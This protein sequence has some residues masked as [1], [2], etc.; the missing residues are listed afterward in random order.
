M[1]ETLRAY[2][3]DGPLAALLGGAPRRLSVPGLLVLAP[4]TLAAGLVLDGART[5]VWTVAGVL[6]FVVLGIA[7]RATPAGAAFAWLLPATLRLGE[8]GTIVV[9]AWRSGGAA[10]AVTYGALAAIAFHHYDIVYRLR[11]QRLPP[12]RWLGWLGGGWE[13]RLLVLTA[14]AWAGV[15]LPV[16][17]AMASWLGL[18]YVTESAAS[19]IAV[20][21]DE[22]RTVAAG[23]DDEGGED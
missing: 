22:Q 17:I 6:A 18:L 12:P 13:V 16:L 11:H 20:A 21:R 5:G 4:V 15:L 8:Y 7:T 14:S 1:T 3:D 10:L 23:P 9:L 19:W 2:R